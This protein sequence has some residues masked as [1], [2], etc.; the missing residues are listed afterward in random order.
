MLP[1]VIILSALYVVAAIQMLF[2]FNLL[3]GFGPIGNDQIVAAA[4]VAL[5][6]SISAYIWI[7]LRRLKNFESGSK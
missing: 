4:L 3:S 2:L 1:T 5:A 7:T 6:L